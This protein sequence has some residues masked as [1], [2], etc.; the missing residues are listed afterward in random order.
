[1]RFLNPLLRAVL[2]ARRLL[3][4]SPRPAA[5]PVPRPSRN[6][7][8]LETL[9]DRSLPSVVPLSLVDKMGTYSTSQVWVAAFGTETIG[10]VNQAYYLDPGKSGTLLPIQG[11][12]QPGATLPSFTLAQWG[13]T[14]N[15][16]VPVGG[17]SPFSGR[18]LIAAGSPVKAQINP[19]FNVSAPD[20]GNPGDPS[21][22]IHNDFFEFTLESQPTLIFNTTLV[23]YFGFPVGIQATSAGS[24]TLGVSVPRSTAIE[25]FQTFMNSYPAYKELY[26][27]AQPYRILS[28]KDY[29]TLAFNKNG[30][31]DPVSNPLD[32]AFDATINSF[33]QKYDGSNITLVSNGVTYTGTVK[34]L[35]TGN[36]VLE[37]SAGGSTVG[38]IYYPFFETNSAGHT[39]VYPLG[40]VPPQLKPPSPQVFRESPTRMVF[41]NDGVFADAGNSPLGALE[42][43]IVA[44][45]NRGVALADP[46]T[47]T[48]TATYYQTAPFN[49]WAAFWHTANVSIGN[50]AYA[51]PYDDQ[52]MQDTTLS[53]PNPTTPTITLGP[54]RP[55]RLGLSGVPSVVAQNQTI[56]ETVRLANRGLE[57]MTGVVVSLYL[58][59]FTRF[60]RALSTPGWAQTGNLVT[61]TL[62]SPLNP[63]STD[64]LRFAVTTA[65]VVPRLATLVFKG[66]VS[67]TL[68]GGVPGSDLTDTSLIIWQF[69]LAFEEGPHAAF[70]HG[71]AV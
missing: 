47:W 1:M 41:A 19:A 23:D 29:L 3:I 14:V 37:F 54:W 52:G 21:N 25:K 18:L 53:I 10:G 42:N 33:F 38:D 5:V 51:F 15:L 69:S 43:M 71:A 20:P 46:S 61:Y 66:R 45:M 16:P 36:T 27:P 57:A 50:K 39:A 35:G 56:V 68:S 59:P 30:G 48:S 6:D 40:P 2:R 8:V 49:A 63:G 24:P 13:G 67:G 9:E 65:P 31:Q 11:N 22:G 70:G 17:A 58:P 7:L 26:N 55:L 28:P 4:P 12:L 62:T 64:T 34:R 44:A 60:D 32:A